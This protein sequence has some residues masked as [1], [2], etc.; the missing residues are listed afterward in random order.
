ML[1]SQ[2]YRSKD[3]KYDKNWTKETFLFTFLFFFYL[4][5]YLFF[6]F[7]V[8]KLICIINMLFNFLFGSYF[9]QDHL[10]NLIAVEVYVKRWS[11]CASISKQT[12]VAQNLING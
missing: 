6:A 5:I 7:L 10:L 8:Q 12:D 3:Q 11:K 4:F 2:F 9:E 1:F